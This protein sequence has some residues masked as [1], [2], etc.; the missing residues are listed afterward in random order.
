[1]LTLANPKNDPSA[2]VLIEAVR[3]FLKSHTLILD[4]PKRSAR[5]V[6]QFGPIP[7]LFPPMM[8]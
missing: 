3:V 8:T 5:Y 6:D 4:A 1:M 2:E 7:S